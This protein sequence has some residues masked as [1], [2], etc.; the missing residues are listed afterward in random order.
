ML[1]P[2][3]EPLMSAA[4]YLELERH[5]K[6]KNEF[7]FGK[8]LP[9]P[10]ESKNANR[11]VTNLTLYF[12]RP[13]RLQNFETFN[14]DVK[15]EVTP[16]GIYRYP[17]FVVAHKADDADKY[18]IHYPILLG[19]VASEESWKTDTVIKRREYLKLTSLRYYLIISQDELHVELCSRNTEGAWQYEM[20][21]NP[22]EY[23]RFP[24]FN[25]EMQL[26]SLYEEVDFGEP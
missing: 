6:V 18:L 8:L 26:A 9:M 16:N 10:G 21:N 2:V 3:T 24:L 25:I 23:L 15:V 19:E 17:D 1:A 12:A 4:A 13:L 14:H 20:L 7:H 22:D 11:I 5:A